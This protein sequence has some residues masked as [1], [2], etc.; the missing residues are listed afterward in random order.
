MRTGGT[1]STSTGS[2]VKYAAQLLG[3]ELPGDW[4]VVHHFTREADATGANFSEGYLVEAKN[5]SR[6]FLKALDFSR[7]FSSQTDFT[8]LLQAMTAAYNF[9]RDLLVRCRE[10]RLDKIVLAVD[11]G[12]VLVDPAVSFSRVPYIIF[13]LADGDI[14]RHINFSK[15]FDVRWALRALHNTATGLLQLHREQIAHQDVKPSNV[16]MFEGGAHAKLGDLGR[17]S[18]QPA[19][20]SFDDLLIP[21]DPAYA[22]PEL[23]YGFVPGDWNSRRYG[24]DAYHLGSLICYFFTGLGMTAMIMKAMLP[25]RWPRSWQGSYA[26]VLPFVREA[27]D[28]AVR[29]VESQIPADIRGPLSE[30]LRRLCD[31][32]PSRRGHPRTR[33][34]KY[35]NPYSL[36]RFV[37]ELDLLARRAAAAPISHQ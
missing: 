6:A 31:P 35:G 2:T 33:A 3:L 32:D 13:E 25:E 29:Q 36:E 8:R 37:S 9:E 14:R 7:A 17:A 34:M 19:V 26:D 30:M 11:D 21:G 12:E 10:R 23:H 5:G 28:I 20:G 24:N 16:M 4:R 18:H 15:Q 1:A 22:P 27:F